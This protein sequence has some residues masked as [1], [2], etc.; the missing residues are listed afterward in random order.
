MQAGTDNPNGQIQKGVPDVVVRHP[1]ENTKGQADS[2]QVLSG[3][4]LYKNNDQ[5]KNHDGSVEG[6]A[7]FDKGN[8][9]KQ[10]RRQ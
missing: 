8:V 3:S 9:V 5:R 2:Q 10:N 1:E 4:E 7:S 6:G